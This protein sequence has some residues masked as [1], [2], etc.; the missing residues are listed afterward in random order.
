[1]TD[2]DLQLCEDYVERALNFGTATFARLW[3]H[4]AGLVPVHPPEVHRLQLDAMAVEFTN[5]RPWNQ[6][7]VLFLM[8]DHIDKIARYAAVNAASRART[9]D[10]I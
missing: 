6:Q 9:Q 1:M 2:Y 3:V 5:M 8:A 10:P 4:A 7:G